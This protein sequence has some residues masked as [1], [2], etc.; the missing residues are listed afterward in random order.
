MQRRM[1][2]FRTTSDDVS[3]PKLEILPIAPPEHQSGQRFVGPVGEGY[4]HRLAWTFEFTRPP[5]VARW[6]VTVDAHSDEVIAFGDVNHYATRKRPITGGVY[7]QT[8]TGNCTDVATCG[9]MQ[10]NTP[11]PFANFADHPEPN[12]FA[13]SAGV[14]DYAGG[15]TATRLVGARVDLSDHACG[16]GVAGKVGHSS[17]SG[18]LALG[19]VN[20]QHDC[21]S[22]GPLAWKRPPPARSTTRRTGLARSRRG[23]C[24]TTRTSVAWAPRGWG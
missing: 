8:S 11:M 13:N 2:A 23:T 22:A 12:R 5:D 7:P 18:V 14:Y 10:A 3:E 6:E 24:P 19:G 9:E 15:T 21:D 1:C 4:R 20:G 16:G 17:S